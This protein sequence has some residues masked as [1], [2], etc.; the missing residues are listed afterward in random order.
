MLCFVG[1][2][3]TAQVGPWCILICDL[4]AKHTRA[5][6]ISVSGLFSVFCA[7]RIVLCFAHLVQHDWFS[8]FCDEALLL[9][10][11]SFAL[12]VD[13]LETS[14]ELVETKKKQER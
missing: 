1:M 8:W 13:K 4:S 2:K 11:D 12:F 6:S 3:L 5:I 9:L 14:D 10:L 7:K